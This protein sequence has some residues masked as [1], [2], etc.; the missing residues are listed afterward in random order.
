M[1][2]ADYQLLRSFV[3]PTKGGILLLSLKIP[4]FVG[5]TSTNK[6]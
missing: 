3:I 2:L 5:M 1:V 6:I 4:P